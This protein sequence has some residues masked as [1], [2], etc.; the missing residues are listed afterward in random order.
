MNEQVNNKQ[1]GEKEMATYGH[2]IRE[3]KK[4][5]NKILDFQ[6]D[7]V[8]QVNVKT[9]RDSVCD[10]ENSNHIHKWFVDNIQNGNDDHKEYV[11]NIEDL[12]HLCECFE[13][14]MEIFDGKTF[15]NK[16][17][18]DT[19]TY[20]KDK[21]EF[22][23]KYYNYSVI[24][25]YQEVEKLKT[26][27]PRQDGSDVGSTEYNCDYFFDVVNTYIIIKYILELATPTTRFYYQSS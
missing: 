21:T 11:V 7:I 20:N 2:L 19:Y 23:Y 9:V 16:D 6:D 13:K 15:T 26:I 17:N 14:V 10:W 1:K 12:E 3:T 8:Y 22:S 4:N 18:T 5:F 25:T 24:L 27:L